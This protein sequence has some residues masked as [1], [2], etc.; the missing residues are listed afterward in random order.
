MAAGGN[1]SLF[2]VDC[3]LETVTGLAITKEFIYLDGEFAD[4]FVNGGESS[5]ATSSVVVN[6]SGAGNYGR[7]NLHIRNIVADQCAGPAL[8]IQGLNAAGTVSIDG[9]YFQ[10]NGTAVMSLRG[11]AGSITVGGGAQIICATGSTAIGVHINDQPNVVLDETVQIT[12]CPKPVVI[13]GASSC[14]KVTAIIKNPII[15]G[16][17]YPAVSATAQTSLTLAPTVRGAA[18]AFSHGVHLI[19]VANNKVSVDPTNIELAA[20]NGGANKVMID[21]TN[22]TAPGY[23]TSAGAAG[24]S[25]AGIFVTGITS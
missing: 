7:Q 4:V 16:G 1:A 2:L 11:G 22:I 17:T 14:A 5:Q 15:T 10:A 9:G 18:N 24:S 23:Y 20:I 19:G 3:A 12:D 21:A 25:G 8:D 6:G 13:E